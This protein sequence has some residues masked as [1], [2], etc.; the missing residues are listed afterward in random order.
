MSGMILAFQLALLTGQSNACYLS[1]FIP[2]HNQVLACQNGQ[3]I[4]AWEDFYWPNREYDWII[5]WQ[6]ESD[7][8]MEPGEY[9]QRLV[10]ILVSMAT[11]P[12]GS[13]RPV[14]IVE[15][16]DVPPLANVR[17]VHQWLATHPMVALIPSAD[18][19]RM[20]PGDHAH[21]SESGYREVVNRI[22]NCIRLECWK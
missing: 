8:G 1:Q 9:A 18:L 14:M 5:W 17:A 12:D 2:E 4:V 13:Y 20:S 21:L 3:S 11:K 16:A 15:V 22:V 10:N 19:P 7:G 6:G